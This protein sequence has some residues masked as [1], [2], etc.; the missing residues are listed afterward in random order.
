MDASSSKA[1]WSFSNLASLLWWL[2]NSFGTPPEVPLAEQLTL[3][4][5]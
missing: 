4:L 3:A 5:G 1:T 2:D